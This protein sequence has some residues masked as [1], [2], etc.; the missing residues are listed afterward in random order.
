MFITT[1]PMLI[2]HSSSQLISFCFCLYSAK[3]LNQM[4]ANDPSLMKLDLYRFCLTSE[5]L[6]ALCEALKTNTSLQHLNLSSNELDEEKARLLLEALKVNTSLQQLDLSANLAIGEK[7]VHALKHSIEV[8]RHPDQFEAE[9]DEKKR[10][11]IV[12][13]QMKWRA[14]PMVHAQFPKQFQKEV[15]CCC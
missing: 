14:E 11:R 7:M 15:S 4:N 6:I 3:V 1:T 5:E 9:M 13:L 2:V 10:A 8:N 12:F